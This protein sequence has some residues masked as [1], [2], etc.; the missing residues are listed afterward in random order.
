MNK[1]ILCATIALIS[2]CTNQIASQV[3]T[4]ITATGACLVNVIDEVNGSED[5]TGIANT[6]GAAVADVYITVTEL[7]NNDPSIVDTA[8]ASNIAA[9]MDISTRR[10][11]LMHVQASALSVMKAK[12]TPIPTVK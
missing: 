3:L 4:D 11:H 6:C 9:D 7:L 2:G 5:A 12:G 10:T 1:F 8:D